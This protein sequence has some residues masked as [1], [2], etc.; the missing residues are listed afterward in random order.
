M[1]ATHSYEQHYLFII[2]Y[3]TFFNEIRVVAHT[4]LR[5]PEPTDYMWFSVRR[6]QLRHIPAYPAL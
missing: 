3:H 6:I 5:T 2:T 4:A 1:E